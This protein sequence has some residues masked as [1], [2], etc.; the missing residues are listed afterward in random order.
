VHEVNTSEIASRTGAL[1]ATDTNDTLHQAEM[2]FYPTFADW[3]LDDPARH[4][5]AEEYFE[6]YS[7]AVPLPLRGV[8][9]FQAR[10]TFQPPPTTTR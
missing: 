1:I 9:A 5:S 3:L 7:P 2:A 6:R 10:P 8:V 4:P